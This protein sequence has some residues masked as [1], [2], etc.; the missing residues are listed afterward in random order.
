MKTMNQTTVY[1]NIEIRDIYNGTPETFRKCDELSERGYFFISGNNP[2]LGDT[3][4]W[5]AY[6]P[7]RVAQTN[8]RIHGKSIQTL[9]AVSDISDED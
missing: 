1:D 6:Y 8:S 7:V 4:K 9:W 3:K 5:A 2:R